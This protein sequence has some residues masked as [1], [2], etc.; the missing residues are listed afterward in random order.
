MGAQS[1][2]RD[3]VIFCGGAQDLM[4]IEDTLCNACDSALVIC[5]DAG[6]RMAQMLGVS[7]DLAVGDFDSYTDALP[8]NI[9]ILRVAAEKDDTDTMLAVRTALARGCRRITLT[10]ALGGRLDHTFANLQTLDFIVGQGAAGEI[11]SPTERVRMLTPGAYRF[12]TLP[13]FSLSVFA[14][15][16]ECADVTLTGVRYPLQ[17]AL[18]TA[19][20]PIGI[21][22]EISADFAGISFS[23]GKL[24]V[25]RSKIPHQFPPA[26]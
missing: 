15:A 16:G 18:L 4:G 13:G 3:A 14:Y 22:N 10:G 11:L 26:E 20:F 7:P 21:S 9:E 5:A 25:I 6:L 2:N 8:Q 12:E 24:L 1:M 23:A 17:N 19:G